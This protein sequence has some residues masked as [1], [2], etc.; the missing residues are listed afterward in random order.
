MTEDCFEDPENKLESLGNKNEDP[1]EDLAFTALLDYLSYS[2]SFD[3][4]GYKPS[5]LKRRILKQMEMRQI[6]RFSDYSDYLQVHPEEFTTLFNTI[7]INVTSFFRDKAAWS[8]LQNQFFPTF[9]NQKNPQEPIRIWSAGC[10]SGEEAYTLAIILTEILGIE[11]FRQRVKIYAT[12]VDEEALGEARRA[13]YRFQKL[14]NLP[15]AIQ[16]KYFEPVSDQHYIF[17]PDL[18]RSVI[19]GRHDLCRDAP[20]SRLDLLVCRNTLMYFNAKT[21]AR[22]LKRFH[23]ALNSTGILFLGKAEML[24]NQGNLFAPVNLQ[25]RIFTCLS[26]NYDRSQIISLNYRP[27]EEK[28]TLINLQFLLRDLSFY[29]APIAQILIDK[30]NN[31]VR[32]NQLAQNWFKLSLPQISTPLQNLEISYRPL[33]LRS[34]IEKAYRDYAAVKVENVS[35]FLADGNQHYFD[36]EI[37]PL[38]QEDQAII[39]VSIN[40]TEVSRYQTLREELEKT[41][42]ELETANE[43]LQSSNEELETTNEELQSTNEELETTNEELQSTNEELETMNEEL[44]STNEE[45]HNINREHR[46]RTL[47]LDKSNAFLNSILASLTAGV[48]VVDRQF[49]ILIWN[50]ASEKF[51]G[52]RAEEVQGQSL[53]SLEIGL[54]VDQLGES[55]RNCLNGVNK[56]PNIIVKAMNRRGQTLDYQISFNVLIAIDQECLGVILFVEEITS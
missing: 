18:R 20:I 24:L 2:R 46:D 56:Q 37:I 12:D 7:L 5:S 34:L 31:L 47:E 3:F 30:N 22:I 25:H 50:Q 45:L 8:Y 26:K 48:I 14:E 10:A 21:Q 49:N 13:C 54:P 33:E 36:V 11:V 41:N 4:T 35:H 1:N 52:L 9:I 17:R 23:F 15:E 44:Q 39:G 40:F 55:I 38:K 19:F 43:E 28:K 32:I 51:W 27:V 53:A 29:Q 42:H 16:S 6:D